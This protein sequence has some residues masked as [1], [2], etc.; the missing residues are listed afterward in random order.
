MQEKPALTPTH[1]S[2][3]APS[4]PQLIVI[5]DRILTDVLM[6][7]HELLR[8]SGSPRGHANLSVLTERVWAPESPGIRFLRRLEGFLA[9]Q[10]AL[11]TQDTAEIE[12]FKGFVRKGEEVLDEQAEKVGMK[13]RR[14]TVW[15]GR[16][17]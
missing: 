10:V 9:R 5:G 12:G 16:T 14:E 4:N 13:A 11:R 2:T 1:T 15:E 17:S 6:G 7:N 3:T 8:P